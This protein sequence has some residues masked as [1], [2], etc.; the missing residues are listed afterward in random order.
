M[1]RRISGR[2]GNT[3]NKQLGKFATGTVPNPPGKLQTRRV[4]EHGMGPVTGNWVQRISQLS[5]PASR[6]QLVEQARAHGMDDELIQTL[7]HMP[8]SHYAS[9]DDLRRGMGGQ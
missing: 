1:P 6:E 7:E 4:E 8:Q 2:T 3:G 9:L 5:F